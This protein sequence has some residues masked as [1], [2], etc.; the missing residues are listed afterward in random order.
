MALGS[1]R[2]TCDRYQRSAFSHKFRQMIPKN[3]D[4]MTVNCQ[5]LTQMLGYGANHLAT[6]RF[7]A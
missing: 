2:F 6:T 7:T 1:L 3:E 5:R 4:G